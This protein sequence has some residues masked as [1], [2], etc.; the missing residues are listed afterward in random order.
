MELKNILSFVFA[1][2]LL[3]LLIKLLINYPLLIT[4]YSAIIF[5]YLLWM[6]YKSYKS[7]EK[8]RKDKTDFYW[9]L[10]QL[11]ITLV[12]IVF[13]SN[14]IIAPLISPR[15]TEIKI[16]PMNIWGMEAS[17][18]EE[19]INY[20]TLFDV[21]YEIELPFF[22]WT[23]HINLR[24][25]GEKSSNID[26]VTSFQENNPYYK[27]NLPEKDMSGSFLS[28]EKF[29]GFVPIII[30]ANSREIKK[31]HVNFI[32]REKNEPHPISIKRSDPYWYTVTTI[33]PKDSTGNDVSHPEMSL[34]GYGQDQHGNYY[35]FNDLVIK[36]MTDLEI[37]GLR[38]E[39][40]EDTIL[41]SE[42][43]ELIKEYDKYIS[44]DLQAKEMKHILALSR[45]PEKRGILNEEVTFNFTQE[46]LCYG[47]WLKYKQ[48]TA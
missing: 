40:T 12:F 6:F 27:I 18:I 24:M 20:Y 38:I 44:I 3:T 21:D 30:K 7:K 41:C 39:V 15:I 42:G 5:L 25:P 47:A 36:S 2:L 46:S 33:S 48:L 32:V 16:S 8:L 43:F 45:V 31:I 35:G 13:L 4:L 14:E 28:Y 37:N 17:A 19:E 11:F 29:K 9:R 26:L 22:L 10:I 1:L 34:I 23:K